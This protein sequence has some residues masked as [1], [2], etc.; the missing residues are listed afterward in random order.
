[1]LYLWN[2]KESLTSLNVWGAST[3]SSSS[4]T[5]SSTT[6]TSTSSTSS[7][8]SSS[9]TTTTSITNTTT[10][11]STETTTTTTFTHT[12]ST[13]TTDTWQFSL[14]SGA[15]WVTGC[16]VWSQLREVP[17]LRIPGMRR[18][19]RNWVDCRLPSN[20]HIDLLRSPV[21]RS[22]PVVAQPRAWQRVPL[23]PQ[24]PLR[25]TLVDWFC[26]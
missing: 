8:S 25:Q 26:R 17:F 19:L 7:T 23:L 13:A 2:Q 20:R 12:S 10:T 1:M 16:P 15:G 24:E 21:L 11:T 14:G 18:C 6:A 4:S 9:R 22:P 3:T 5:S